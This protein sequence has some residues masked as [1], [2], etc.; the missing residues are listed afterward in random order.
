MWRVFGKKELGGSLAGAAGGFSRRV[1]VGADALSLLTR[2]SH[3][4]FNKLTEHHC[5]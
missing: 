3:A 2:S 5:K 4:L 1:F